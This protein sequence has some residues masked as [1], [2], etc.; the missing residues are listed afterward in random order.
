MENKNN[1][2][3]YLFHQGTYYQAYEY[4]GAHPCPDGKGYVFRTWAPNASKINVVGDFNGWDN[5]KNPMK[6]ISDGGV[7]EAVVQD[8]KQ[9][10]KY[11]FEI[12][13]KNNYARLKADPY[14]FMNETNGKTASIVYDIKGYNWNDQGYLKYRN[15][16]N[17]YESPM[18]IYE[19]NFGSWKKQSDCSYYTYRMLADEL[20]PYVVDMGYTH[21]EIMPLTEYP[22]DGSWGYQVTGYFSPTSRFGEPKDFMYFVDKCH[23]WGISVIMDWVPAHFPKDDFGLIEFDGSCLYE[24]QGWDRKEHKSWGTRRF[25]YGRK[26]VQC[27]LVSS[28]MMFLKEYHIDG[29]RVDAVA[30]MLYL[31]YDKK[32]GEWIPNEFGNNR[33]LEAVAFLQKLNASIFKEFSNVLM[34]AEES[35]A[36]PLVTKPTS[37]GGLGFNFKWNIGWMNDTL[38]YISTDPYFRKSIHNKLTFSM[39][40]AFSENFI[41]PISHDEVVY[42]KCSLLN[43][44]Y[45]DYYQ[46]FKSM[47]AYLTY[48]F[49]HPGKKL[50]FMGCEFAQ[51]KEWDYQA[52]IDFCLLDF[53][54]HNNMHKFVKALNHFY[55]ETSQLYEEDFSWK[56]FDWIVPDDNNQNV[57]VFKRMD[58]SGNELIYAVNFSTVPQENYDIPVDSERYTEVFSS[59]WE[60]FG[61][62]GTRNGDMVATRQDYRGKKYKLTIKIPALSGVFLNKKSKE[63]RLD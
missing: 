20:I 17:N 4:M 63:I 49:A 3:L 36:W 13:D 37:V 18:N 29:I 50:T 2:Q 54:T 45:G 26:E 33:N 6:K 51:F 40:Y 44:M 46:K 1:E 24:N 23:E 42:G 7:W 21:I 35:T 53:E 60:E 16:K 48:M 52:G 56:G 32:P 55:L 34:I 10:D 57:L 9:F 27:F 5:T 22:F 39:F 8:A 38:E 61:G 43:K 41:L 59:D 19:V 28:A 62:G 47:R 11:K 25:D 15:N 30:S 58:K 31:D 12:V 14:A